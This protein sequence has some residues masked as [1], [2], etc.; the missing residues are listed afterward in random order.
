MKDDWVRTRSL[1]IVAWLCLSG[2]QAAAPS[3]LA[4]TT[5]AGSPSDYSGQTID[6]SLEDS[7]VGS[8]T[9]LKQ[10]EFEK[11]AAKKRQHIAELEA[12]SAA[13]I[14]AAVAGLA[15]CDTCEWPR[16]H[17]VSPHGKAQILLARILM[18]P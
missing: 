10:F 5:S 8:A 4:A 18:L 7:T 15:P 9:A 11:E 16:T 3:F 2:R 6:V 17:R 13:K 14:D 1:A 12:R